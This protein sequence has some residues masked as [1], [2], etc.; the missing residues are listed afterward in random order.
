[1]FERTRKQLTLFF[2]SILGVVIIL[3]TA[4]FYLLLQ[5]TLQ[6][7]EIQKLD[8]LKNKM[9]QQWEHRM[10]E[11]TKGIR[12]MDHKI[13][14]VE[15]IFLLTDELIVWVSPDQKPQISP[16]RY[17]AMS[18]QLLNWSQR[19]EMK[20]ENGERFY[21]DESGERKIFLVSSQILKDDGG[22][23]WM[24]I[25]ISSNEALLRTIRLILMLSTVVLLFIAIWLAYFFAGKAMVPIKKSYARQVEFT[26]NASHELRTPLSVIHSSVELL[27]ECKDVLPEFEQHILDSLQDEVTRMIRLVESLLTLA[28]S[29]SK[30][31]PIQIE[32]VD[33]VQVSHQIYQAIQPLALVKGIIL[34]LQGPIMEHELTSFIH[35]NIDQIKQLIYIILD[36]AIK[37]TPSGGQV[38]ISYRT[39][40]DGRPTLQIADTGIGI[41]KDELARIF[42]RFYRVDK[43]RSRELGGAGLGLSIAADILSN[44]RAYI[45]VTSEEGKG[46]VFEIEFQS[47]RI[48]V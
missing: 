39:S 28:R 36:N 24:A 48:S 29:D 21:E 23:Y 25:D 30:S 32:K 14:N 38:T 22:K 35:G 19:N 2:G 26:T 6:H 15:W 44:H 7:N 3:I 12:P 5:E 11:Q 31:L 45:H 42:E 34:K 47:E 18:N 46:S 8:D 37:Y 27:E 9:S 40:Q 1:M 10:E 4:F 33:L 43:A 13:K 17:A 16:T 20:R 41:P